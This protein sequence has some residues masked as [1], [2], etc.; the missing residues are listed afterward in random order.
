MPDAPADQRAMALGNRGVTYGQQGHVELEIADYTAV[1]EM[2]D[3]P[4]ELRARALV[5]RGATYGLQGRIEQALADSNAV[6]DMPDAPAEARAMA[7]SH[8]GTA[9]WGGEDYER[10]RADYTA[11]VENTDFPTTARRKAAFFLPE[12]MIPL[13]S[14]T[15]AMAAL[16]RAFEE[17]DPAAEYY[18]GTPHDVL[19]VVLRKGHREWADY[20]S[21]LVPIYQKHGA[22]ATLGNGLTRAIAFLDEGDFSPTQLDAWND[23]WQKAGR[24]VEEL[25]IPLRSLDCAVRAIKTGSDRPLFE[26]PLEVRELV[27]PLLRREAQ[28]GD[29]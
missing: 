29:R 28:T 13:A 18:G 3:A 7:L 15:D 23:A 19:K 5:N 12:A 1:V 22:S 17:G 20:V 24:G 11:L 10:S 6:I 26:L 27:A 14:R 16:S 4:A 8:R 21:E 2:P 25:E 9:Y